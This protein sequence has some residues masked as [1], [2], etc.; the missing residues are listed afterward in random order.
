MIFLPKK[1]EVRVDKLAALLLADG[2]KYYSKKT[3]FEITRH[4][5][6]VTSTQDS[7]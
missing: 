4:G 6:H 2:C 3:G 1:E 7:T 5:K